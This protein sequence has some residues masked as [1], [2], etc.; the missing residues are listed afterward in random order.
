MKL[1]TV[2]EGKETAR[3][4]GGILEEVGISQKDW[5]YRNAAIQRL[6]RVHGIISEWVREQ[7][8]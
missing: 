7:R 8:H 1:W 4:G 2:R 6:L 5:G 3:G